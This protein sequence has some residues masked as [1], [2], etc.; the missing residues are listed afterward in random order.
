MGTGWTKSQVAWEKDGLRGVVVFRSGCV[1]PVPAGGGR[2]PRGVQHGA[3]R[4][5]SA[6]TEHENPQ[7]SQP[8][9]LPISSSKKWLM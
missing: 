3:Q 4:L 1:G 2:A 8:L 6:E 9:P 7:R 5:A